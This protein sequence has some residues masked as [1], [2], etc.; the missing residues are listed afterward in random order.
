MLFTSTVQLNHSEQ[1]Q[2]PAGNLSSAEL[3][4]GGTFVELFDVL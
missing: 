2:L 1:A 4:G 3:N